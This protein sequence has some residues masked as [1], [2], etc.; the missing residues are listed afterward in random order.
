[1]NKLLLLTFLIFRI[2]SN[3]IANTFQKKLS[4][5]YSS[6][7]INFYSYLLLSVFSLFNIKQLSEFNFTTEFIVLVFLCGL[8]CTLGMICM[9][10]AV[11]IGELSVLGPINSYKSILSL[12]IAFFLLKEIP[13]LQAIIGV[14]LIVWGSRYIFLD[15][16]SEFSFS[17]FKRKEIQLRFLA[18]TLTAIEAVLL[19]KIILISSVEISFMFWC[20]MGFFWS[21]ILLLASRKKTFVIFKLKNFLFLLI[22]ALCLGLMQYSTNF[23]FERMEVGLALSLFQLSSVFTVLFGWLIFKEKNIKQKL[24]GCFIMLVGSCFILI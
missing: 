6:V 14:I 15:E 9:I 21:L 1:M 8:L 19:K 17:V 12:L 16:S 24:I 5:E 23:V 3:P 13:S 10:K 18:M 4:L 20:F 7:L 22:I 2:L 11:N